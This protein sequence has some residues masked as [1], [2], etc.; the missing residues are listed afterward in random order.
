MYIVSK[1]EEKTVFNA[2]PLMRAN[3]FEKFRMTETL[4]NNL[5]QTRNELQA[6]ADSLYQES[7]QQGYGDGYAEGKQAATKHTVLALEASLN[8]LKEFYAKR[9]KHTQ[10][11]VEAVLKKV[12][13]SEELTNFIPAMVRTALEEIDP[14]S[15]LIIECHP[16]IADAVGALL[17]ELPYSAEVMPNVERAIDSCI[18]H[19]ETGSVDA[20]LETQI[21]VAAQ[22]LRDAI[23]NA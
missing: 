7:R 9:E 14:T 6:Q 20:S 2:S 17:V 12:F 11:I 16:D 8:H 18:F 22:V 5:V 15:P 4:Y 19:F 3:E 13:G 21:K 1:D 10:D 23:N